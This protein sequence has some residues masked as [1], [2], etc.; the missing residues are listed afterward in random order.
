MNTVK[1]R[2]A[3]KLGL[4]AHIVRGVIN[5]IVSRHGWFYEEIYFLSYRLYYSVLLTGDDM[6]GPG[7]VP[8]DGVDR[9]QCESAAFRIARWL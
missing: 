1:Q 7:L 5:L 4:Q 3:E 2:T 6:L 9:M 8:L